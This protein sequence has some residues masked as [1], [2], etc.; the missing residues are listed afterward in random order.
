MKNKVITASAM[1]ADE[2]LYSMSRLEINA[3]ATAVG[4]KIG[5]SKSDTV[6]NLHNAIREG[7][8]HLKSHCTL[9]V[10][11]AKQ[12]EPTQRVTYFGKTLRTYVSGQGK[13]NET[14]ITPANPV[15][16]SR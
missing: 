10:N 1:A 2:L 11:P 15:A 3:V 9:S 4:I 16:G 14:W 7:K 8:L 5:K 12:G 13:G 6:A